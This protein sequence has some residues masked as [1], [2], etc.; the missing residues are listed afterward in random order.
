MFAITFKTELKENQDDFN[1]NHHIHTHSQ[2]PASK[3]FAVENKCCTLDTQL[4]PD[5]YQAI[6]KSKT[7]TAVPSDTSNPIRATMIN[8]V[9]AMEE[10]PYAVQS[11]STLTTYNGMRNISQKRRVGNM[12]WLSGVD[13]N[14]VTMAQRLL[15]LKNYLDQMYWEKEKADGTFSAKKNYTYYMESVKENTQGITVLVTDLLGIKLY[16]QC[17]DRAVISI[18]GTGRGSDSKGKIMQYA[19]TGDTQNCFKRSDQSKSAIYPFFEMWLIGRGTTNTANIESGLLAFQSIVTQVCNRVI[20][21]KYVKLDGERALINACKVLGRDTRRLV[22]KNHANRKLEHSVCVKGA[23][24]NNGKEQAAFLKM[25]ERYCDSTNM[26]EAQVIRNEIQERYKQTEGYDA[27]MRSLNVYF[28][29]P[30]IICQYGRADLP[31]EILAKHNGPAECEGLFDKLKHDYGDPEFVCAKNADTVLYGNSLVRRRL[32][33]RFLMDWQNAKLPKGLKE[34][35]SK[36]EK[37]YNLN[38]KPLKDRK[39]RPRKESTIREPRSVKPKLD[40]EQELDDRT[41]TVDDDE[42]DMNN[43]SQGFSLSGYSKSKQGRN[44]SR[45]RLFRSHRDHTSGVLLSLED[46]IEEKKTNAT[47]EIHEKLSEY[48]TV[49]I[50]DESD[51]NFINDKISTETPFPP[52]DII[53]SDTQSTPDFSVWNDINILSAEGL[54]VIPLDKYFRIPESSSSFGSLSLILESILCYDDL[55]TSLKSCCVMYRKPKEDSLVFVEIYCLTSSGC[56]RD[57]LLPFILGY[58]LPFGTVN[59]NTTLLD[60]EG[61]YHIVPRKNKFDDSSNIFTRLDSSVSRE[62]R[63]GLVKSLKRNFPPDS[64]SEVINFSKDSV[65]AKFDSGISSNSLGIVKI[66]KVRTPTAVFIVSFDET[67]V[68][69]DIL[70]PYKMEAHYR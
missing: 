41:D 19:V 47:K 52:K 66:N 10:D 38:L 22:E 44:I 17:A 12:P 28:E 50:D 64:E 70:K 16:I 37:T 1:R 13:I 43:P 8:N 63:N 15:Y 11:G 18:D 61:L 60:F 29:D 33:I 65:P 3:T 48:E 45:R 51:F 30:S 2:I 53:L 56:R 21:P 67:Q 58:I 23:L 55:L 9:H 6:T 68:L 27:M 62:V 57:K 40:E 26:M 14:N 54:K 25:W 42:G 36:Y 7:K 20:S 32:S 46:T 24:R 5:K 35:V 39:K 49:D 69:L 31:P 59:E 4:L 34:V